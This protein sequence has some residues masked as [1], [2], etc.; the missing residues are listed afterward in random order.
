MILGLRKINDSVYKPLQ[1]HNNLMRKKNMSSLQDLQSSPM[2]IA[3]RA[4]KFNKVQ[5]KK[6]V[7]SNK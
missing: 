7:K 4:R 1:L 6:L 3:Q 5:A 2:S